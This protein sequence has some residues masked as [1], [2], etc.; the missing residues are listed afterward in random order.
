MAALLGLVIGS[1][2]NVLIIR[3]PKGESIVTAPSHCTNCLRRLGWYELI[4]LF[5]WVF[6]RGR[7]S[8]C[9]TRI[10]ALY[11]LVE[12]ATGIAFVLIYARYGFTLETLFYC[13]MTSALLALSVIDFKTYEIPP[14]FNVFL[15]VVGLA[16][17]AA[18]LENW[19]LYV[20]GFASVGGL[21]LVIYLVSRGRGI[22][23]GDVKLMAVCGLIVG[24]KLILLAF[25]LGCILGSG[26]HLIRLAVR[27]EGPVLAMGPYLSAGVFA[28]VLWGGRM[29]DAYLAL[30]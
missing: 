29:I 13:S 23:G 24:W 6:L 19:L 16:R 9:K 18:D 20:L 3:V 26:V 14:G 4:P 30:F 5:S 15:L 12:A 27:G 10:S 8:G 1:F 11:P 21:L 7:C 28:A 2:L 17:V 22:G 25:V